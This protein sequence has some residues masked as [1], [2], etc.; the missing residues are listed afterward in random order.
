MELSWVPKLWLLYGRRN[1]ESFACLGG[2]SSARTG[3]G[4]TSPSDLGTWTPLS[5]FGAQGGIGVGEDLVPFGSV[6]HIFGTLRPA[7]VFWG[8]AL[9]GPEPFR[10]FNLALRPQLRISQAGH[11]R[12]ARRVP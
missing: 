5:A 3:S 9:R 6:S 4:I 1:L 11:R 8:N 2:G 10:K 12:Q 7:V